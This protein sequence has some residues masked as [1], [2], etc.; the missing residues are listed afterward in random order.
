LARLSHLAAETAGA[1]AKAKQTTKN[2]IHTVS[3]FIASFLYKDAILEAPIE[4]AIQ[5]IYPPIR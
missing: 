3:S 1:A 5:T 2:F 4:V